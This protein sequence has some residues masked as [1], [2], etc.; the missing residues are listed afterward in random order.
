MINWIDGCINKWNYDNQNWGREKPNMFVLLKI[1]NY[2]ASIASII[3]EF[4]K[5]V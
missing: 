4:I 5:K 1:L 3:S 2:P